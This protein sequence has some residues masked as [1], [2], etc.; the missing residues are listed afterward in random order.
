MSSGFWKPALGDFANKVRSSIPGQWQKCRLAWQFGVWKCPKAKFD[1]MAWHFPHVSCLRFA[2]KQSTSGG[3]SIKEKIQK[4]LKLCNLK[5]WQ[6]SLKHCLELLRVSF[7]AQWFQSFPTFSFGL[8][9]PTASSAYAI[10]QAR[11][12]E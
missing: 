8:Y 1:G 2:Q 3:N 5:Y 11:I 12:L 7:C 6:K 9:S 4:D 10:F